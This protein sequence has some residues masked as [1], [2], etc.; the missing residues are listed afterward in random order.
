MPRLL[1]EHDA[2]EWVGV[3]LSEFRELVASGK[4]PKPILGN[5]FD[6]RAMH[7]AL[8]RVSGIGNPANALDA[9]RAKGHARSS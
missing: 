5:K 2:A 1:S 4:L 7:A 3:G 6:K 8:D 9:W